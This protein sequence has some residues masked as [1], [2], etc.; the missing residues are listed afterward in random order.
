MAQPSPIHSWKWMVPW[1]VSAVKSGATSLMRGMLLVSFAVAVVMESL[2]SQL[3]NYRLPGTQLRR[4]SRWRECPR[5]NAPEK[6]NPP[7]SGVGREKAR[8]LPTHRPA[9]GNNNTWLG[10]WGKSCSQDRGGAGWCQ[11]GLW[12]RRRR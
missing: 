2:L 4:A 8:R 3:Y 10:V 12:G 5:E 1:V 7:V 11:T 9:H 6:Q